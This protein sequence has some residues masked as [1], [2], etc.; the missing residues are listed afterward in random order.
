[1]RLA[2]NTATHYMYYYGIDLI[3]PLINSGKRAAPPPKCSQ[4]PHCAIYL[5]TNLEKTMANRN[6]VIRHVSVLTI[7]HI[8]VIVLCR[9][10][11][12]IYIILYCN[13][14]WRVKDGV[15]HRSC[16]QSLVAKWFGLGVYS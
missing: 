1:M 4:H 11:S 13:D 7:R 5:T 6:W 14:D 3:K 2:T 10:Y 15:V 12:R 16:Q 9:I 8:Y